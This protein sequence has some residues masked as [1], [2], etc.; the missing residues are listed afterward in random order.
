MEPISSFWVD[1][2]NAQNYEEMKECLNLDKLFNKP[3]PI[4]QPNV[5]VIKPSSVNSSRQDLK[6]DSDPSTESDR[7]DKDI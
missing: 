3:R 4:P 6:I 1:F 5:T 2:R 7:S